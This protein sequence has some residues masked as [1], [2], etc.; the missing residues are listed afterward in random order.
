MASKQGPLLT[1]E[2]SGTTLVVKPA[3]I[4]LRGMYSTREIHKP[5]AGLF[6]KWK[7]QCS[8]DLLN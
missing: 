4:M 3:L 7:L 2:A 8:C 1:S 6:S 5:V